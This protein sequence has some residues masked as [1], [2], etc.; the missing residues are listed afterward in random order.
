[1]S[2]P[3]VSVIIPTFNRLALLREALDS[4]AA[5]TFRDFEVIIIDDGSTEAIAEGVAGHSTSPRVI[6]QPNAGPAAARNR[7]IAAANADLVAF[8]DSDDLWLPKKLA[9]YFERMHREPDVPIWYGPMQ[10]IERDGQR[11]PGRTKPCI[12]GC[13]TEALFHSSFVHVPTVVCRKSLLTDVGCFDESLPVCEDYDLWL[14][15]SVR[16]RFGLIEEPLALRRL[17]DD[18]LSKGQM[19]RNLDVKARMLATFFESGMATE[20]LNRRRAEARL[21]K[22]YFAAGR[23]ALRGG[24]ISSALEHLRSCRRYGGV[25]IQVWP[26]VA[27]ASAMGVFSKN[28]P[29][30]ASAATR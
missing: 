25:G 15:L 9:T 16:T 23:A 20:K 22:V 28:Q 11:V 3:A 5:Q 19:S 27:A 18:R 7:G 30:E 29:R 6:R 4:V 26:W 2:R 8:L 1:M 21:A 24:E 14:R 10:P 12:G 17:H 13:I